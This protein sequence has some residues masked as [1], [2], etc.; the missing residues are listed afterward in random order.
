MI[1]A[2][3][4][5][6]IAAASKVKPEKASRWNCLKI[7]CPKIHWF[8]IL[9]LKMTIHGDNNWDIPVRPGTGECV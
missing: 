7:G 1:G 4:Y 8:L 6:V 5:M 2:G 3:G 9:Q